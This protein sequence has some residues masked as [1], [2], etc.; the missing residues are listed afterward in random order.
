MRLGASAVWVGAAVLAVLTATAPAAIAETETVESPQGTYYVVYHADP[1][2]GFS[3]E[4]GPCI[5]N[6]HMCLAP[7][8]EPYVGTP[9]ADVEMWEETNG[10]DG[11]QREASDCNDDGQTEDPDRNVVDD[12]DPDPGA[13]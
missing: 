4:D 10:C 7:H 8:P 1:G 13:P 9:G 11:L 2:V 12:L 5:P 3:Q 6:S